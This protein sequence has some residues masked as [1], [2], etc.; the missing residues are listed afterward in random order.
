MVIVRVSYGCGIPAARVRSINKLPAN[1]TN[2][3]ARC[4]HCSS[5]H[6]LGTEWANERDAH[7]KPRG[8]AAFL[9]LLFLTFLPPFPSSFISTSSPAATATESPAALKLL[10]GSVFSNVWKNISSKAKSCLKID[11]QMTT[12]SLFEWL[13][14]WWSKLVQDPEHDKQKQKILTFFS[15]RRSRIGA[16]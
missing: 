2:I 16:W 7:K 6:K 13:K 10:S 9:S 15:R 8:C 4:V 5:I 3:N 14:L 1:A 12:I 11:L